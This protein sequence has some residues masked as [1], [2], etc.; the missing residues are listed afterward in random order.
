[1][2]SQGPFVPGIELGP[3]V[4]TDRQQLRFGFS[5]AGGPGG[6]NVNKV[7]TK[8][9]LRVALS[10]IHGMSD[11]ALS[12]LRVIAGR[13]VTAEG[14]MLLTA[15][16][17]RTQES[18]RRACMEKLRT[19]IEKALIEPK[20]RRKSKPSATSR[21]KRLEGKKKRGEKKRER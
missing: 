20:A 5:R 10:A 4:W 18:N 21:R 3:G 7:N 13:R 19:L 16:T 17:Q 14:E 11:R 9:E 8:T 6:Q 15:E 1:M 2:N 12:R